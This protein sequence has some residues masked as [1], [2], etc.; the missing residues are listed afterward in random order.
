MP[1]TH[2][3]LLVRRYLRRLDDVAAEEC[4]PHTFRNELIGEVR[5][6]VRAGLGDHRPDDVRAVR[7]VLLGLGTPDAMVAALADRVAQAPLRPRLNILAVAAAICG[8]LWVGGLGSLVALVLGYHALGAIRLSDGRQYGARLA[9]TA[10][11][12]GWVGLLVPL[13]VV[14]H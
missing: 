5:E 2:A 1:A 11:F 8:G 14:L 6:L 4:L 9:S 3:E 12:T 7:A 10:I 13:V